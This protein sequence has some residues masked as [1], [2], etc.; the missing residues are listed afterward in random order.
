[1]MN[2]VMNCVMNC[3]M[4]RLI[5]QSKQRFTQHSTSLWL[6]C[7]LHIALTGTLA[8]HSV[9]QQTFP[10]SGIND[11]RF[12]CYALTNARIVVSPSQTLENATIVVRGTTIEA[13]GVG[14]KPPA[15]AAVLNLRGKTI[16]PSFIEL[17]SD[18]GMP[19]QPPTPPRR[20]TD[21]PQYE[22][23]IKGAYN[24][25]QAIKPEKSAAQMF[26]ADA[27]K[28]DELR[29]LGFGAVLTHQHDGIARGTS[30]LVSL[31]DGKEH[32]LILKERAAAHY[33]FDK[34]TSQQE[35]PSSLMGSIALLRQTALDAAWYK[36]ARALAPNSTEINLSLEAWNE[37]RSL[38]H[39]FEVTQKLNALRADNTGDDMGV[40]VIIRGAGDEYQRLED[41]KATKAAFIV[42][43]AYPLAFNLE[44]PLAALNVPLFMMKH[45]E[46]APTNAATLEK[47]GVTFALTTALLKNRTEFW[48]NVRT[49][50]K[51]GLSKQT[52][53]AALTTVPAQLLGMTNALGTLEKGKLANFLVTS[54]DIFD[55]ETV[56]FQNWVQGRVYEI[57]SPETADIRGSYTLTLEGTGEYTLNVKG[58]IAA[59]QAELTK[60]G[61][62]TTITTFLERSGNAVV[63]R[64]FASAAAKADTRLSGWIETTT[65]GETWSGKGQNDNSAWFAWQA[66][67][68]KPF[69]PEA[70]KP[71]T[72]NPL[73]ELGTRTFPFM[74]FGTK[75]LPKTETV[76]LKNATVWTCEK[77]GVLKN[78]D[79]L[80]KNGKIAAVGKNLSDAAAKI[81][82]ATGKHI[83][84]GIID[85]HS[86]IALTGTNE[87]GQSVTAEV[88]MGDVI[89]PEDVNIYRQLAGGVTTSHLLHGSANAIGGQTALV[90]FRWGLSAEQMKVDGADGFI[91]FA[92]GENVK[93]S[94]WGDAYTIRFPQT[95]MG[96]EQVMVD[97]FTRAREY[98]QAWKTYNALSAKDKA[99]T[100][101]PRRDLELDA[102]LE[103]L[104]KKRFI[105]CH[106][107]VQSE[108]AMLMRVA[109]QFGFVV[110]TFTHILEGYKV[111]DKM[112]A[113]G[114][115]A[116][117]FS[118]W[119]AYKFEVN[120][121]IPYNGAILYAMGINV[122]YNSDDAEMARR[123]N[124]EAAKAV[125]YGGVPEEEALKFVTLNPA[126]MLHIDAR[127]GSLKVGKDADV[128][129]WS[130]HPL[131]V[132]A[133][134][135]KTFV[136]GTLYYDFERDQQVREEMK[137]ER[138]RLTQKMTKA[139][140]GGAPVQPV[141][142]KRNE[143]V[144]NCMSM[145]E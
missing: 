61:D 33:S 129:V 62:T 29:K 42:P 134:A 82:D 141:P 97:A 89:N 37:S 124:Q 59:P 12:S 48:E 112:K 15:D 145:E 123:L 49:A 64:F 111:A 43:V 96:V 46:L 135:E 7:V 55:K 91:K 99:A 71:D 28:A 107:Y 83:T 56:I 139:K 119:W 102:V 118:D 19:V 128:V 57:L 39:I 47:A 95:R 8:Q 87:A 115:Q 121:A 66:R 90:K 69:T 65:G 2:C 27:T 88:R 60:A 20:F 3:A 81:V 93:Q 110:N 77:E 100:V 113:H 22:S 63:M 132:Y 32:T 109:E 86:H 41:I 106:S 68:T 76:L 80:I 103:V 120:D 73:A 30:V 138:Q 51:H 84:P 98:E 16:M 104:N 58:T 130:D 53:L 24:W 35:Y 36:Q 101:P 117:S 11:V 114:A 6:L 21:P 137:A 13:V 140:R 136:D 1:M 108:I 52:A 92:L 9:A 38:P 127:T 18:Y 74:D 133:R 23:T 40:Q 144:Y 79:V 125:K 143:S 126:K 54:G 10:A 78:A 50:L 85:E 17:D 4:S 31:G 5:S 34:G 70:P 45:W 26:A 131:S 14:I 105:T 142:A 67:R 72:T 75:T 116:S 122:A 94:N 44:D 25:N